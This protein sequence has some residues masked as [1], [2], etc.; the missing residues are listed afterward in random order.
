[1]VHRPFMQV[2]LLLLIAAGVAMLTKTMAVELAPYGIRVN[3]IAPGLTET[4]INRKDIANK[5]FRE[6]RL[7]RIPL[8]IIATP[9]D[10][11]GA[12]L[13]LASD[14]A[15]LSTGQTVWVDGGATIS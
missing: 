1:M 15:R 5:E 4:D 14:D 9:D 12:V 3:N 6:A 2:L 13:F 11:T 10:I 8:K 7:A